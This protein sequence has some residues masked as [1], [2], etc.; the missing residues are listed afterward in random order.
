MIIYP[1]TPQPQ[2]NSTKN[3]PCP[4]HQRDKALISLNTTTGGEG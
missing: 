4:I 1:N 2:Q 3:Y